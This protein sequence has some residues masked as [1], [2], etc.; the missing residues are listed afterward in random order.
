MAAFSLSPGR[1]AL[2]GALR[3]FLAPLGAR[4]A[5][6]VA[7]LALVTGRLAPVGARLAPLAARLRPARPAAAPART[8]GAAGR[9]RRFIRAGAILIPLGALAMVVVW[10]SVTAD[11]TMR[12]RIAEIPRIIVPV[13]DSTPAAPPDAE[14]P[15]RAA[16]PVNPL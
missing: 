8:S 11:D 13:R 4:L 15:G 9:R 10:L 14:A 7:R 5:P 3:R 1:L 12:R 16:A 6:V 2:G